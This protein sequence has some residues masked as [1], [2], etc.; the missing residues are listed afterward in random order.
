M[1]GDG[2]QLACW[3]AHHGSTAARRSAPP[4]CSTWLPVHCPGAGP[5]G[6]RP[7]GPG[8]GRHARRA[9]GR[10]RP[11]ARSTSCGAFA[12][13]DRRPHG[14]GGAACCSAPAR[15]GPTGRSPTW[16]P[17]AT[18]IAA[19]A[20]RLPRPDLQWW[21]LALEASIELAAGRRS[22]R[23]RRSSRRRASGGSW[24]WRSPGARRWPSSSCCCS[25]ERGLGAAAASLRSG[26]RRPSRQ[27]QL[28]G[29][30]A[31]GWRAPRPASSTAVGDVASRLAVIRS[32]WSTAGMTW[33]RWSRCAPPRS[34]SRPGTTD[35]RRSCCGAPL[36]PHRG[37]GWRC[38]RRAT[39]APP[40]AASA[41]S[42]RRSAT[43]ERALA[44][45]AVGVRPG[46]SPGRRRAGSG[47]RWPTSGRSASAGTVGP[48][49][50]AGPVRTCVRRTSVRYCARWGSTTRRGRGASWRRRSPGAG[51]DGR[52]P[53]SPS[54]NAGGDGP[55][56]S[57][58]RQPFDR[59]TASSGA[60]GGSRALRRAALPLQLLVPRRRVAPR[61][62]GHRGGPPRARG[63]RPHRPRRLLRRR[64][65]RR[66]GPGGRD[67]DGVRHRDHAHA[68]ARRR[69]SG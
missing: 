67:A 30:G 33:G 23:R 21:P 2:V 47:G 61:G 3:A 43:G 58:R 49:S 25:R 10:R 37:T 22:R 35:A 60:T 28:A 51:R 6:P 5:A 69:P 52:A 8:A 46:A 64:P 40:T 17:S 1:P 66:G 31:T 9:R 38:P 12:D 39:S 55:A 63:A 53:G 14:R 11:G 57:R 44:L 56:W 45:L 27:R 24:A 7:R 29:G 54:W 32:S 68:R 62:A 59:P 20:D 19:M 41:C 16:P 15:P 42:P 48:R 13:R 26:W 4:T 50:G 65:L 36:E 18:R 34:P